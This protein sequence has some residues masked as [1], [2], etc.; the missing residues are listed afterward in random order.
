MI[1]RTET[2]S[3][4]EA[5]RRRPVILLVEDNLTQLDLYAMVLQDEFE[6]LRATRGES[7]YAL[8]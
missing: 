7:D 2:I 6:V 8:A 1:P 5:R 4:H 3:N